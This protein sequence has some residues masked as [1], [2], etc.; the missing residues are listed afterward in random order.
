M[1]TT[2]S[3][4]DDHVENKSWRL[5]VTVCERGRLGLSERDAVLFIPSLVVSL[6][7]HRRIASSLRSVWV[8]PVVCEREREREI[9][10]GRH[11]RRFS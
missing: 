9:G 5:V 2:C 3:L 11:G 8:D 6:L 4:K 10:I 7:H 1:N